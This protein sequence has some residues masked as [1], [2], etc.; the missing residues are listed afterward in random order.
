MDSKKRSLK[1]RAYYK[2]LIYCIIYGVPICFISHVFIG[3]FQSMILFIIL[4][5]LM[6]LPNLFIGKKNHRIVGLYLYLILFIFLLIPKI[7]LKLNTE[8][9]LIKIGNETVSIGRPSSSDHN[10]NAPFLTSATV[11][12][13]MLIFTAWQLS[14]SQSE[15]GRFQSKHKRI[16][17]MAGKKVLELQDGFVDRPYP[18]GKIDSEKEEIV[19]FARKM[20]RLFIA[21]S[22]VEKDKILLIISDYFPSYF[23]PFIK[24]NL[25]KVTYVEFDNEGNMSVH[26]SKKDYEK[27]KEELTF[28]QLCQSLGQL[29]LKFFAMYKEG[30]EEEILRMLR[31]ATK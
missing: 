3:V 9:R 25:G 23:W 10:T 7:L 28:D 8:P 4:L 24:P 18:A 30:K 6:I 16:L 11:W 15:I 5:L 14:P 21:N 19:R 22:F 12:I 26:I 27:Y 1:L 31:S 20:D 2:P 17:E 29:I 13:S